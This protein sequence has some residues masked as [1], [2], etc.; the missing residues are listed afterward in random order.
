MKT[1]LV[2]LFAT[3]ALSSF[4]STE[5]LK[6]A[7]DTAGCDLNKMKWV[8]MPFDKE[9]KF[10]DECKPQ[11]LYSWVGSPETI[12]AA[13]V[14]WPFRRKRAIF[15]HRTPLAT[16]MYGTF[17]YRVKLK[18]N[19]KYKLVEWNTAHY[20]CLYPE[21][22]KK[23]TVY[24]NQDKNGF[25]EYVLCSHGPVESWSF[26]ITEHH[27][28]MKREF[29]LIKRLGALNVDGFL[30]PNTRK[31]GC[32]NCFQRYTIKDA[33][34]DGSESTILKSMDLMKHISGSGRGR[35]YDLRTNRSYKSGSMV[36]KHFKTNLKLPFH[37]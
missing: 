18:P 7:I 26:G 35:V 27:N 16:S 24:V 14:R 25:S 21:S 10:H 20:K 28:E 4:A 3:I 37:K 1:L 23:N 32:R 29:N 8:G 11:I 36:E 19:V 2:G 12:N 34:N 5:Q 22:E 6:P 30:N 13:D 15:F 33:R 17:S 31:Y 9:G